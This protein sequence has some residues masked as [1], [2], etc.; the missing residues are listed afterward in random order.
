[1][2]NES[3][4]ELYTIWRKHLSLSFTQSTSWWLQEA[5]TGCKKIN[6]NNNKF[7]SI[8]QIL[9]FTIYVYFVTSNKLI[10]TDTDIYKTAHAAGNNVNQTSST[11]KNTLNFLMF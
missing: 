11:F 1:M 4:L 6:S 10:S 8:L 5:W 3:P 7:W 2:H 9:Q